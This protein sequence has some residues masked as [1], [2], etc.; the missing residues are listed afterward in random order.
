MNRVE[1]F[2]L[3][4]FRFSKTIRVARGIRSFL[5]FKV[6]VVRE[7]S[8]PGSRTANPERNHQSTIQ[9]NKTRKAMRRN[10]Q[11][12]K[13]KVKLIVSEIRNAKNLAE[14]RE[15]K[16]KKIEAQQELFQAQEKLRAANLR[17]SGDVLDSQVPSWIVENTGTGSLPDFITIG[18]QKCGTTTFH[19]L[20]TRHPHVASA[21][22]K[23]LH[24]FDNRFDE[25]VEWYRRCFPSPRWI[26]GRKTITGECTPAYMFRPFVPRRVAETIPEI[27]LIA[28][29][30]NPADRAYS[31]YYHQV[32][33]GNAVL[34]FDEAVK[35][36]AARLQSERNGTRGEE[37]QAGH[38]LRQSSYLSR[39][40]YVDQ[41]LRWSEFFDNSQMLVL[42]SED[43][44]ENTPG[45]MKRVLNFL[46]LPDWTPPT[47]KSRNTGS[48]TPMNPDTRRWLEEYFA[49]HNQRLYEY[50]GVDFGW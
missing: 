26:D 10:I 33:L 6:G 36:E 40:I 11:S 27:R 48:Y 15:H 46:G 42:N 30:R 8:E 23:E 34:E 50:L 43:F 41:L 9:E 18:A 19:R 38:N 29:L 14:K 12:K 44:F 37:Y 39:G 45:T 2:R 21:A 31:H 24:F 20:L 28:L 5:D 16:K 17:R 3:P 22:L 7:T 47:L 35:A 49:P 13:L 25:G 4:V 32:R 1:E